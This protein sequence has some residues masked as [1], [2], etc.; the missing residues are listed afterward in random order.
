MS[1]FMALR[2]FSLPARSIDESVQ[3]EL[4][5]FLSTHRVVSVRK[6]LVA[7]GQNSYWAVVMDFYQRPA[8]ILATNS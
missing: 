4:N 6:E 1:S 3:Q 7:D 5:Q 2:S 8:E